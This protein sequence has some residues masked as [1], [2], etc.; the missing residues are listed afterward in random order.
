MMDLLKELCAPNEKFCIAGPKGERGVTGRRGL[1]G[2]N[3]DPGLLG[4]K[5]ASGKHGPKGEPGLPG[6]HG[7]KGDLGLPGK[8]GPEGDPG[9]KGERG[10]IGP[11]GR[12]GVRGEKGLSGERGEQGIKGQKGD[13]GQKG[14]VYRP[15]LP[16]LC[17]AGNYKIL[18]DQ[19]RKTSSFLKGGTAY[20]DNNLAESW[21]RFADSIGGYM[22]E[23]CSPINSCGTHATGWVRGS[24]PA[25]VGGEVNR[26]V[27]F[28]WN[29]DCCNWS[30]STA[31]LNCG[32]FFLYHLKGTPLCS[33]GYCADSG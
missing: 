20:C 23:T 31:I 25:L 33:L 29:N 26:T 3:G 12:Q 4:E 27:C 9:R 30:T 19:W 5:G 17:S 7:P 22:P 15:A 32:S 1:K 16:S 24:H 14:D 2:N 8:H 10:I 28:H 13:T 18:S 21:Y 11:S 6:K